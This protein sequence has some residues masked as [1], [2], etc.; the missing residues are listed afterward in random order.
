MSVARNLLIYGVGGAAS[1]LAAIFLVPLYTRTLPIEDYG[2]LEVLLAIYMGATLL[3]GLQSESAIARDYYETNSPDERRALYWNGLA[4]SVAGFIGFAALTGLAALAGLIPQAVSA[5]LP[6]LLPMALAAQV[7]G[8]QL[9]ILRFAAKPVAFAFLSFLDLC[10]SALLSAAFILTLDLGITGALAGIL[11]AKAITSLL[12]WPATFALR[13]G[14]FSRETVQ[15]M[16]AYA[17][18]TM[19]S[20]LMNW[21][22]TTGSRVLLALFFSLAAVGLVGI[23]IKVAALYG[24]LT[25]SFRLAWEPYSFEKLSTVEDDPAVYDRAFQWYLL[26]MFPA[27]VA[28]TALSP[29]IL[30]ILAPPSYSQA[31]RLA[32]FFIMGQFWV[33]A[34][35]IFGIGIHGARVTALLTVVYGAGAALF[36]AILALLAGPLGPTAAAIA[37]V[38]SAILSALVAVYF[39]ARHFNVRFGKTALLLAIIASTTFPAVSYVLFVPGSGALAQGLVVDNLHNSALLLAL[40]LLLLAIVCQLGFGGGATRRMRDQ[41]WTVIADRHR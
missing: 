28:A 30:S 32:G 16:L 29:L 25:Y 40:G 1:R 36:F 41:L 12:A 21:L 38:S 14:W 34:L 17:I 4:I 8:I 13:R 23:A 37:A 19:P 39:S 31:A 22:Q 24:F 27:A 6:W 5:Y 3:I 35:T 26:I 11:A 15:R 7:L 9:V 20:V 2:Q 33:G 10:L 18:P